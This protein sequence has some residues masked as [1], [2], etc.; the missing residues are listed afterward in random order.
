M[1]LDYQNVFY[2]GEMSDSLEEARSLGEFCYKR[3]QKYGDRVLL[4][5]KITFNHCNENCT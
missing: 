4:V 1:S 2:G 3:L 5:S